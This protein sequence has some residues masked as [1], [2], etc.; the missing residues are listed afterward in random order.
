MRDDVHQEGAYRLIRRQGAVFQNLADACRSDE[1]RLREV[2][3]RPKD[4]LR[5]HG[6]DMPMDVDVKVVLNTRDTFHL[7]MP[8][9]PNQALQDESLLAVA[10]GKTA[11]T[12]S[13]AATIGCV[14]STVS[15][16]GSLASVSSAA[17][18]STPTNQPYNP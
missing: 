7:A 12:A 8:P 4:V 11:G 2:E 17:I 10:G 14:P 6:I 18:T 5:E 1:D 16:A 3:E 9:D 15:T 13:S